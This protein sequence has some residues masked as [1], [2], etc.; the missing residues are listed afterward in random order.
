[1]GL[2]CILW[3]SR[4][5]AENAIASLKSFQY[6][7]KREILDPPKPL[8][9]TQ[10]WKTKMDMNFDLE[11]TRR[12]LIAKRVAAGAES[13]IGHR[14][15]NLIEQLEHYRTAVGDQRANLAKGIQY[16]MAELTALAQA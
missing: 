9:Q 6:F 4:E 7:G 14:C 8:E 2:S 1:M 10:I 5:G 16:Q 11:N 12:Q 13:E 3:A 15:S